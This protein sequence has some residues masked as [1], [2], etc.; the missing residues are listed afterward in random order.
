LDFE[1]FSCLFFF[2]QKFA[3]LQALAAF[4]LQCSKSFKIMVMKVFISSTLSEMMQYRQAAKRAILRAGLEPVLLEDEWGTIH[5]KGR[6]SDIA[7]EVCQIVT[8]SDI[9]VLLVGS[10]YGKRIPGQRISWIELEAQAANASHKPIF[11]YVS[12]EFPPITETYQESQEFLQNV[13]D[14]KAFRRIFS[15]D[16]LAILLRRDLVAYITKKEIQEAPRYF[17]LPKT[18]IEEYHQLF[19]NPEEFQKCSS[20]FF[21]ELIADLLKADGWDVQLVARN[22]APGPDIIAISSKLIHDVPM[23]LIVECKKYHSNHPVDINVVRK[24]MYWVNQEYRATFGMIA[25]TSTFSRKA[26]EEKDRFHH[27]RLDLRDQDR[28]IS[29][30]KSHLGN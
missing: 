3:L 5:K 10:H 1:D 22:N 18:S 25:T 13:S 8:N 20:R 14:G 29:W 24:V 27:W 4:S 15:P 17:I 12:S 11:L 30:L 23:K 9:F 28:I 6:Q 19:N 2:R 16:Q 7:K 21:E 26:I